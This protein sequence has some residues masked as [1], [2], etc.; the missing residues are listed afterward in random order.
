MKRIS[1]NPPA[2]FPDRPIAAAENPWWIAKIKPRMEKAM[3]F[4]LI[5]RNVEYYLPMYTKVTRRRDN[6]K[7]RKSV[8]PL[9]PGYLSF[10]AAPGTQ[11]SIYTTGRV[12]SVI[13]VRYQK[14]FVEELG[15]IYL[16]LNCGMPMEP[17]FTF[18]PGE[19]VEVF[20]GPLRGVHGVVTRINNEHRLVLEV[21]GLGRAAVLVDAGMVK[22]VAV[23]GT[24]A[25]S[26]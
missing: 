21:E 5:K 7:P 26:Q 6:N 16:G 13:E 14:R 2:R 4:D 11:Q 23:R 24:V 15:Q 19:S 17:V 9:F 8:L 3:A 18:E 10:C 1:E 22:P 20:A 25:G 12:V